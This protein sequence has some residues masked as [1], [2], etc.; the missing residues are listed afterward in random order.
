MTMK[1]N[2]I[3]LLLFFTLIFSFPLARGESSAYPI[4]IQLDEIIGS[5]AIYSK[6]KEKSIRSLKEKI[7]QTNE[8]SVENY[9]LN[10]RLYLEYKAYIC[11]SALLYLNKS[12]EIAERINDN[13]RKMESM[14]LLAYLMGSSGMYKEGIDILE[15]IDRNQLPSFLNISYYSAHDRLYGE[16]GYYTQDKKKA[17]YYSN[18]SR[19]Y[20]DSLRSALP[21]KSEAYLILKE[22]NLRYRNQ[23]DEALKINNFR[24]VGKEPGT[25]EHALIAYQRALIFLQ[26]NNKE[27]AKYWFAMSALSDIKAATKDHASLWMLAQLLY[28]EGDIDRAYT[29][30]RF[31]WSETV[32]YN[33]RLRSLQSAV[34]LSLIDKTYQIK[35]ERKNI[36]LRNSLLLISILA[37]ILIGALLYIFR[38]IH[39]L[40]ITRR[41]L[42]EANLQLKNLN[43]EL[44]EVNLQLMESNQIKEE[45]IGRFLKLCSTYIEKLEDYRR[46]VNKK[47]VNGQTEEL[48]KINNSQNVLDNELKKLYANFDAAFLR[49]FPHFVDQVNNLL[50]KDETIMLK[51]DELLN[52]ELRILALIRLGIDDS[53]QIADFLRYSLNTIY[54]YRSK[55]KN[56]AS[57]A[58][59]DFENQVR[60]IGKPI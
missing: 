55:L 4:L 22:E 35:M 40:S 8:Y 48:M 41:N 29:Y 30:I 23:S 34:L 45:Y 47:I 12:I 13:E 21:E 24:L 38:Q 58:R 15:T 28:E 33:A 3:L 32:F 49:F 52:T 37:F 2:T 11:D 19:T 6:R 14:L 36:K 20:R 17:S 10:L 57:I 51:K 56:K 50:Q 53:V 60:M 7:A 1:Q 31:S 43:E 54:N 44:Q 42:Q 18:I 46:M 59:D 5:N 39:R 16:L 27:D 25:P 26:Q 9:D